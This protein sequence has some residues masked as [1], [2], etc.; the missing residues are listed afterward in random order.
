MNEYLKEL[1]AQESK[2]SAHLWIAYMLY[3]AFLT[4]AI[5]GFKRIIL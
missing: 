3:G 2:A 5:I 1:H 4:I